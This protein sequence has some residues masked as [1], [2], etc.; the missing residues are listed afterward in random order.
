MH[1]HPRAEVWGGMCRTYQA[2]AL[3][4]LLLLLRTN[5]GGHLS[6][7]PP[8]WRTFP[9]MTIRSDEFVHMLRSAPH[10]GPFYPNL[11]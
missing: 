3:L 7:C 10:R 9:Y 2:C 6:T 8:A 1:A 11:T 4:L 5:E